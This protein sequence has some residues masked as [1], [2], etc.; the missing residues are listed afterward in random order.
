[1]NPKEFSKEFPKS[2]HKFPKN[3][4]KIPQKFIR[5]GKY[6]IIPWNVSFVNFCFRRILFEESRTFQKTTVAI[7]SNCIGGHCDCSDNRDRGHFRSVDV[8]W[9]QCLYWP[10]QQPRDHVRAHHIFSR[11]LFLKVAF[12]QSAIRF[13]NLQQKNNPKNYPELEI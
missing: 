8:V 6:P 4:Q 2:S 13:S 3:T 12:F 11:I 7:L 10:G 5:F 9:G 1:M